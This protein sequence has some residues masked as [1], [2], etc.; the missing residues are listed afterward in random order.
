MQ[1]GNVGKAVIPVEPSQEALCSTYELHHGGK[2]VIGWLAR[3]AAIVRGAFPTVRRGHVKTVGGSSHPHYQV[4]KVV[5]LHSIVLKR[6]NNRP[7]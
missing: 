2:E 1:E 6:E 5:R 3:G 4:L 7:F